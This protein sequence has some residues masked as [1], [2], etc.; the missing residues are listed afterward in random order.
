MKSVNKMKKGVIT[1][2][3]ILLISIIF[4]IGCETV[5]NG[6]SITAYC[7]SDKDCRD[8]EFCEFKSCDDAKGRCIKIP[9]ECPKCGTSEKCYDP[10]C[11]CD[12]ETYSNDCVRRSAG[13]SKDYRRECEEELLDVPYSFYAL[14]EEGS[15]DEENFQHFV[16]I[17][18]LAEK[19]NVP[20]TILFWP[21]DVKYILEDTAK[22][23]LIKSYQARG[24]EIGIH[25]QGAYVP[26]GCTNILNCWGP[27]DKDLLEQYEL[28]LNEEFQTSIKSSTMVH[29]DL[30]LPLGVIYDVDSDRRGNYYMR[31]DG[32]TS[33][34]IKNVFND[35]VTYRLNARGGDGPAGLNLG[36]KIRE[37]DLTESGEVYGA[38][39][40]TVWNN[41]DEGLMYLDSLEDWFKHISRKD[42]EG[43]K[44]MT[45]SQIIEE[46]MIPN[47]LVI[48]ERC[49]NTVW[50]GE[51]R[52]SDSCPEDY[53][54]YGTV[55]CDENNP[56]FRYG[57]CDRGLGNEIYL[58]G[59]YGDLSN[60][61][62]ARTNENVYRDALMGP[63]ECCV[64]MDSVKPSS[65]L[66][67]RNCITPTDGSKGTCEFTWWLTCGD[68][69][70][71]TRDGEDKC[72]CP[73]DCK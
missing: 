57:S 40:H 49:G 53:L 11:G 17:M 62:C 4:I 59:K 13:V 51:E 23:R 21:G 61:P 25:S 71:S 52:I 30:T 26:G 50:D 43:V 14:H 16:D 55:R 41:P 10:V 48:E 18:D 47:G 65:F 1:I 36:A 12:G 66:D 44:R 22:I 6:Y 33:K 39:T 64:A 24:H 19:Y 34:V 72:N 20:V 5:E 45:V 28:L 8:I 3:L 31:Q 37:Y 67:E 63:T 35:Q 46:Y 2:S 70:C 58:L 7:K 69:E 29:K 56:V 68:G 27:N 15:F 73:E 32:R 38:I 9:K 42:P 54:L 60:V